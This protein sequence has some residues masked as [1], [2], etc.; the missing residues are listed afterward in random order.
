ME[1]SVIKAILERRSVRSFK[2]DPVA[3]EEMEL[4]IEAGLWAPSAINLQPTHIM[5]VVGQEKIAALNS[6]VKSASQ[7]APFD[8]YRSVVSNPKYSINFNSAPL[9]FVVGTDREKSPCLV[10]DGTCVLLNILLAA[11]SLGL[12]GCWIN[13]LGAISEEPSF[14]A[15]LTSLGF[16]TTHKIVGSAAIGH[17][18]KTSHPAPK[19]R[20]GRTNIVR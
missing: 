15:Y 19:R 13:Q 4:I 17:P 7:E 1:N 14:R 6:Q 20:P 18:S 9:F 8:R 12:G 3:Q 10:E 11:H 16:P 2:P 5:V